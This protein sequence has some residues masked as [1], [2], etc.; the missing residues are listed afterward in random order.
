[1]EAIGQQPISVWRHYTEYLDRKKLARAVD[2]L[3]DRNNFNSFL[4]FRRYSQPYVCTS[5][6]NCSQV[7]YHHP[8]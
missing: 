1:M 6:I 8:K 5:A 7:S 4:S 2:G 3:S